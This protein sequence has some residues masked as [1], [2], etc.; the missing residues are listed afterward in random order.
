MARMRLSP[1]MRPRSGLL[2]GCEPQHRGESP[3]RSVFCRSEVRL[4]LFS[5]DLDPQALGA[6]ARRATGPAAE[7]LPRGR[8]R[9][10]ALAL[11]PLL[12][13]LALRFDRTWLLGA[14]T[15]GRAMAGRVGL[16]FFL[17]AAPSLGFQRVQVGLLFCFDLEL[18]QLFCEGRR[19]PLG[20]LGT[21]A[22]SLYFSASASRFSRHPRGLLPT[23]S[24]CAAAAGAAASLPP[25]PYCCRRQQRPCATSTALTI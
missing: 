23:I 13:L 16:S 2:L 11:R 17:V 5:L 12:P 7:V 14:T 8:R 4:P 20:R 3:G 1:S 21:R 19:F 25:G 10:Q 18:P 22:P 24:R 15:G 9:H 6:G